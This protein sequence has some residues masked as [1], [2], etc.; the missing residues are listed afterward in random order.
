MFYIQLFGDAF[1]GESKSFDLAATRFDSI[2]RAITGTT[3]LAQQ[4]L[5]PFDRADGFRIVDGTAHH[6]VH[7]ARFATAAA[8]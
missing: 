5:F 7:E 6:A 2:E 8:V 3:A 1:E 4:A